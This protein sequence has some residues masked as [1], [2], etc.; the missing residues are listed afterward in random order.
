MFGIL[1]LSVGVALL[2]TVSLIFIGAPLWAAILCYSAIGASALLI[3][4][5][6]KAKSSGWTPPDAAPHAE[7]THTKSQKT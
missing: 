7:Q 2:A 5:F 1:F 6:W 4:G 3:A